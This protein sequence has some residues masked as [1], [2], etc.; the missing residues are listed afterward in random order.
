MNAILCKQRVDFYIN[1][2]RNARFQFTEYSLAM[3]DVVQEFINQNLGD[4]Q[5]RD[6]RNF[7]WVQ[8]ISDNLYTL[9][10]IAAPT[11]TNG[12]VITNKYYSTLPITFPFPADYSDFISVT[13]IIDSYTV[14]GRPTT[15]NLLQPMLNDSFRHPTNSK[16]VYLESPATGGAFGMTLFRANS[17]SMASV[18]LTYI[19]APTDFSIGQESNLIAAGGALTNALV[20]YAT[21]VSVYAGITYQVGASITGTG[22]ALTSGDV[23]LSTLTAAP[24][25]PTN[26]H[27]ELCKRCATK[28]LNAINEYQES[29]AIEQEANKSV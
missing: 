13:A 20:Y 22:A 12:T 27:E 18:S 29:Q 2:T 16:M 10:K 1:L 23:I 25:L 15:Y 5:Q 17:G 26:T 8:R 3:N 9:I 7:Q 28:M 11:T 6:P 4:K 21:S 14:Y 24:D 19:K